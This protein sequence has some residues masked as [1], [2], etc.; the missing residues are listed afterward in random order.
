MEV[1]IIIIVAY[2]LYHVGHAH[3]NYKHLRKEYG[4]R[5]VTLYWNSFLGPWISIK[6][7]GGF[8][9]GHKL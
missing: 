4:K 8:R 5:K 1:I 7:P 3:A 6:L 9:I 2:L